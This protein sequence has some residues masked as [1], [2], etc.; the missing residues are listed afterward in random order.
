[1]QFSVIT[2]RE[3]RTKEDETEDSRVKGRERGRAGAGGYRRSHQTRGI[4]FLWDR[5]KL[6][7][8]FSFTSTTI[9]IASNEKERVDAN[10]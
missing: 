7:I 6:Q 5:R 1:M 4:R 8:E 9:R 3:R 2:D 10:L